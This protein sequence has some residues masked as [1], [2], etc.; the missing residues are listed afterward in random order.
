MKLYCSI[1]CVCVVATWDGT[2]N[3][4]EEKVEG[5]LQCV[6]PVGDNNGGPQPVSLMPIA[7]LNLTKSTLTERTARFW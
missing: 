6:K 4:K 1:A 3:K 7:Y 5:K 2:V